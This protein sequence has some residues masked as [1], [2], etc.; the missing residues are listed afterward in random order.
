MKKTIFA[1][2]CL[3]AAVSPALAVEWQSFGPRA[4]GMGGAG[5]ALAQG[6]VASYWNPAGLGQVENPS[7]FELP[8]GAQASINGSLIQG[9]KD[10]N[11]LNGCLGSGGNYTNCGFSST[12]QANAAI[13]NT[14]NELGG[15][16]ANLDGGVGAELKLGRLVLFVNDLFYAGEGASIDYTHDQYNNI[17]SN[18][19]KAYINGISMT[20]IG[21]GYGHELP[22]VKGLSVGANLKAIVGETGYGSL[23]IVSGTNPTF[24]Q[25]NN[26]KKSV[27]PGID[28]GALWDLN[29]LLPFLP[30]RPRAALVARN[31][32]AP[33]F[34]QPAAAATDNLVSGNLDVGRQI[35]LGAAISPFHWWNI[36]ADADL[37]QNHTVTGLPSREV[38]LGTEINIFN[39]PWINIPLRAGLSKNT[40]LS[41]S[42]Y[43]WSLGAGLNFLHVIIDAAGTISQDQVA[44]QSQGKSTKIPESFGGMIQISV[45][46]G[47][48]PAKA[49]AS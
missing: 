26:T 1:F 42:G 41:N 6:P 4:M 47:G 16:G 34:K 39:R 10:L 48:A 15:G 44:I 2:C 8:V 20:E 30:F 46:F 18:T 31:I 29:E 38:A 9:V 12:T 17:Q 43:Q 45:L 11:Q 25:S 28:L 19:S 23:D 37:T 36:A 40:A 35:R 5:V 32:N 21:L 7:G 33:S 27:E 24:S 13:Q 22:W 14:L 49:K 3:F